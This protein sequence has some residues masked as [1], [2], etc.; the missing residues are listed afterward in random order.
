MFV[1][2]V[3]YSNVLYYFKLPIQLYSLSIIVLSCI[4]ST[5]AAFFGRSNIPPRIPD[6]H[7]QTGCESRQPALPPSRNTHYI[8]NECFPA[9]AAAAHEVSSIVS[10]RKKVFRQSPFVSHDMHNVFRTLYDDF[11]CNLV[12]SVHVLHSARVVALVALRQTVDA[13]G[14]V[15]KDLEKR[16]IKSVMLVLLMRALKHVFKS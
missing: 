2:F 7:S 10:G 12:L 3:V 9:A 16:R 14:A 4:Q 5:N 1:S 8:K 6:T 11:I 13:Q 15:R